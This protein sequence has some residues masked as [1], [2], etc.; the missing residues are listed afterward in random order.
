VNVGLL[1]GAFDPPHNG[2]LALADA[3]IG[4]FDLERLV[5][6]PTGSPPHKRTET[7]GWTRFRLAAAAFKGRPKIQLNAHELERAGASYTVDTV[8]WAETIWPDPIF[9]IG[10][11]EF[12]DFLSWKEPHGVL[13]HARLGVATRPGYP[14]ELLEPVLGALRRPE[15]VEMFAIPEVP[16][17]SRE[18]RER[19]S[20][21]DAIDH[22]VPPAVAEAIAAARLYTDEC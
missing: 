19:V 22:L 4:H 5:V 8:R 3:A 9:L 13:E 6:L 7:D 18:I 11:D 1:G 14:R 20:R 15:R 12:A 17:S 16:I 2:H 21:G 10:A